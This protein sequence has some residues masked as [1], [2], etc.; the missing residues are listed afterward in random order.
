MVDLEPFK[1]GGTNITG[2]RL[3]DPMNEYVIRFAQYWKYFSKMRPELQL[4]NLTAE[5]INVSFK[6]EFYFVFP[7]SLNLLKIILG[8]IVLIAKKY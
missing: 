1:Y 5:T 7:C 4:S 3:V 2:V 6:Y 8:F